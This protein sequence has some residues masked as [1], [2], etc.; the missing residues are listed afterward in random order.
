MNVNG[1]PNFRDVEAMGKHNADR[2]LGRW[3]LALGVL[4]V[5]AL[6]VASAFVFRGRDSLD[7]P[8]VEVADPVPTPATTCP[9]A[10]RV[11]TAASFM[12]VL[13]ALAAELASGENCAQLI[14]E[15]VNGRAA[16]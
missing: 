12:P 1:G 16:L 13:N 15:V 11:V 5:V 2:G 10:V 7:N 4:V 3:T 9:Q 6:V 8:P 14:I